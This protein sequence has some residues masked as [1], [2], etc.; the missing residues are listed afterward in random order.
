M[1]NVT[2]RSAVLTTIKIINTCSVFR[3]YFRV[4]FITNQL[5]SAVL[6]DDI[7]VRKS[8]VTSAGA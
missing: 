7:D 2:S 3:D 1:K 8:A 6:T 5:R 4:K